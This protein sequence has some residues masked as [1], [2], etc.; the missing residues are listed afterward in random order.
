M[1]LQA[2]KLGWHAHGIV[3]FDHKRAREALSVS[4]GMAVEVAFA[5][6]RRSDPSQLNEALRSREKPSDRLPLA[7]LAFEGH[8]YGAINSASGLFTHP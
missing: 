1:T 2:L 3:G 6:G 5:I 7:E 8:M 4:A